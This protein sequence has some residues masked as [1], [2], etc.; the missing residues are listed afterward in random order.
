MKVKVNS[1][2][3]VEAGF[4]VYDVPVLK[5]KKRLCQ[6]NV[7]A[8]K[9]L[10]LTNNGDN[11]KISFEIDGDKLFLSWDL[12]DGFPVTMV[13]DKKNMFCIRC[14]SM[15]NMIKTNMGLD[16]S[17]VTTFHIAE[18]KEGRYELIKID[19]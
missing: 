2:T 9:L 11:Q 10:A 12:K 7:A 18:F 5:L 6:F 16:P 13:E 1:R 17:K 8:A 3:V 4:R 19:K 14:T 15:V